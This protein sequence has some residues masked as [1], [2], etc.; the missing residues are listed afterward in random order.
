MNRMIGVVGLSV[1]VVFLPACSMPIAPAVDMPDL[2]VETLATSGAPTDVSACSS[3]QAFNVA[4]RNIGAYR[5]KGYK[6]TGAWYANDGVV[7]VG[8]P[9]VWSDGLDAGESRSHTITIRGFLGK[10]FSGEAGGLNIGVVQMVGPTEYYNSI[11]DE[12][13]EADYTNNVK[14]MTYV[15]QCAD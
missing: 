3:S 2:I 14:S 7:D 6:L 12:R 8:I 10:P 1:A 9:A 5:A 4:V 15:A 13:A 11:S